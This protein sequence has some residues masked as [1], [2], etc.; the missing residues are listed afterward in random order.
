MQY[1][2]TRKESMAAAI[3]NFYHSAAILAK[4]PK[5]NTS[6]L[7][8]KAMSTTKS[9]AETYRRVAVAYRNAIK[10]IRPIYSLYFFRTPF[11]YLPEIANKVSGDA[12]DADIKARHAYFDAVQNINFTNTTVNKIV[13]QAKIYDSTITLSAS[14]HAEVYHACYDSNGRADTFRDHLIAAA[15]HADATADAYT[16]LARILQL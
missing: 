13:A 3:P 12:V 15:N 4:D 16:N 5:K 2:V 7:I 10:D 6:D 14:V 11:F 9:A 1:F 8:A